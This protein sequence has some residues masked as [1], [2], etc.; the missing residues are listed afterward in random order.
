VHPRKLV[1]QQLLNAEE[2]HA[3][4]DGTNDSE[5]KGLVLLVIWRLEELEDA[6]EDEQ[7]VNR[8]HPFQKIACTP[9]EG[10]C[11]APDKV[12]I[13][14]EQACTP[15]EEQCVDARPAKR[16]LLFALVK[17]D[18]VEDDEDEES[19]EEDSPVSVVFGPDQDMV[20]PMMSMSGSWI[21]ACEAPEFEQDRAHHCRAR[22]L[23]AA[24]AGIEM[25]QE[26]TDEHHGQSPAFFLTAKATMTR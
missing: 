13:D 24:D 10:V 6:M 17:D 8:E 4:N 21:I 25:V 1:H 7:V 5:E 20:G 9:I 14:V 23:R 22:R 18:I 3:E 2:T 15:N 11:R 12:D 16:D 19:N 26:S